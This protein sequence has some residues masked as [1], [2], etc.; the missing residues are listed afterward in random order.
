MLGLRQCKQIY[1]I[2]EYPILRNPYLQYCK[3]KHCTAHPP[4]PTLPYPTVLYST[5][6]VHFNSAILY[7]S[8]NLS[9]PILPYPILPYTNP[10]SPNSWVAH[11]TLP[12]R[13]FTF[14]TPLSLFL[15]LPLY[16]HAPSPPY[17]SPDLL[18]QSK[19]QNQPVRKPLLP[20]GVSLLVTRVCVLWTVP[21]SQ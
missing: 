4:Y 1:S 12:Q 19:S 10:T 3:G 16:I 20:G 7:L 15:S 17:L 21:P 2:H 8:P 9:Y 6:P 18:P 5:L 13:N 11:S 14:L